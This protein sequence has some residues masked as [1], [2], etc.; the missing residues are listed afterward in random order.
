[1]ISL[2]ILNVK[3]YYNNNQLIKNK[4]IVLGTATQKVTV[5]KKGQ[6]QTREHVLK[7]IMNKS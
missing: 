5:T 1:M 3:K 2:T 4:T 7:E 6:L